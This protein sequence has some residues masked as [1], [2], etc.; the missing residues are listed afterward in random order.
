MKEYTNLHTA[1]VNE[2]NANIS[3]MQ[4]DFNCNEVK[5][6]ADMISYLIYKGSNYRLACDIALCSNGELTVHVYD[7]SRYKEIVQ[8]YLE[9]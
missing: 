8:F 5:S 4:Y 1:D 3:D 7:N 6:A 2:D 9:F